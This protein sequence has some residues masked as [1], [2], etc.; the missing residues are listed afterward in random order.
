[1][2]GLVIVGILG[3]LAALSVRYGVDSR[4]GST[5]PRRPNQPVGIR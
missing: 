3:A 1:M 4:D 5:D 2:V